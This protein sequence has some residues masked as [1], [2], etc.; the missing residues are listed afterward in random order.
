MS[1]TGLLLSLLPMLIPGVGPLISGGLQAAGL[2]SAAAAALTSPLALSSIGSGIGTAIDTHNLGKGLEAG[3]GSFAL[4]G[5]MNG[6]GNALHG[7]TGA[8]ADTTQAMQ[9]AANQASSVPQLSVGPGANG[10]SS[11]TQA[12]DTTPGQGVNAAAMSTQPSVL[13]QAQGMFSPSKLNMLGHMGVAMGSNL[14]GASTPNSPGAGKM[15]P[16]KPFMPVPKTY[17]PA[18]AGY[19]PGIDP[20]HMYFSPADTVGQIAPIPTGVAGYKSGTDPFPMLAQLEAAGGY[21]YADGG[22]VSQPAKSSSDSFNPFTGILGG[23]LLGLLA[24]NNNGLSGLEGLIPWLSHQHQAQPNALPA[25]GAPAGPAA[26]A[27]PGQGYADG[28]AI[29]LL[30]PSQF[31]GLGGPLG[32]IPAALNKWSMDNRFNTKPGQ[33]AQPNAVPMPSATAAPGQGYADGGQ[34]DPYG[35][36]T[37]F[38]AQGLYNQAFHPSSASGMGNTPM[39]QVPNMVAHAPS[40]GHQLP[41]Y[42]LPGG[43]QGGAQPG[44]FWSQLAQRAMGPGG[45]GGMQMMHPGMMQPGMQQPT[46]VGGGGFMSPGMM[47]PQVFAGGGHVPRISQPNFRNMMRPTIPTR[48]MI[49]YRAFQ[50]M[51]FMKPMPSITPRMGAKGFAGGGATGPAMQI[52]ARSGGDPI[53]TMAMLQ[54]A[55]EQAPALGSPIP[56]EVL[57]KGYAGGGQ[58]FGPGDGTSDSIPA[59]IDGHQPAALSSGEHVI[60]ADVVAHLGNG[61]SSAGSQR[62]QNMIHSV[63]KAKT[64]RPGLPARI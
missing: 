35:N 53:S 41:S 24:G 1:G 17:I 37:P 7:L 9:Q 61:S 14:G 23:G 26:T 29:N 45:Q 32:L 44:G 16:Y 51:N 3:L 2:G 28:G 13:Q 48:A 55:Q 31:F 38:G 46:G 49:N 21:N 19:R 10:I 50:P 42:P 59:M 5:L 20:E 11:A 22:S 25:P 6:A 52:A 27:A 57:Q 64:G 58:I 34:V 39:Q 18:P 15:P 43:Q 30:G 40:D 62:L 60:P 36:S 12:L 63:R 8:T 56:Q 47:R 54:M 33:P 4:G